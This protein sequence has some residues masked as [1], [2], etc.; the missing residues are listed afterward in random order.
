M[1]VLAHIKSLMSPEEIKQAEKEYL[2]E[3]E[4]NDE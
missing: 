3:K 4:S 1:S 2:E